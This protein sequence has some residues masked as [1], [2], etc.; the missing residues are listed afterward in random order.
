MKRETILLLALQAAT[1]AVAQESRKV[2]DGA[3]A[4]EGKTTKPTLN[5]RSKV[6]SRLSARRQ[7]G[8][9]GELVPVLIV[10]KHQPLSGILQQVEGRIAPQRMLATAE[11]G[12]MGGLSNEVTAGVR[13]RLSQLT[14]ESRSMVRREVESATGD[15]QN[16]KTANLQAAGAGGIQPDSIAGRG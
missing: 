4:P 3:L 9:D 14:A 2:N 5:S 6:H 13:A 11:L 10:Y 16:M 15:F 1:M 12:R 8:Q 7:F